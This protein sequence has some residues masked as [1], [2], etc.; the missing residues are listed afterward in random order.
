MKFTD[1]LRQAGQNL[2]R[3]KGRTLLTTLG[4]VVGC[5][6]VVIMISIGIGMQISTAATLAQMGDL[7]MITVEASDGTGAASL[8]DQA[9][10]GIEAIDGVVTAAPKL[11]LDLPCMIRVSKNDRYQIDY[12]TVVGMDLSKA[13]AVGYELTEGEWDEIK[14]GNALAGEYLAYEF[15]DTKRPEGYNRINYYEYYDWE[16][17][18]YAGLPDPYVDL[19]KNSLLLI[20]GNTDADSTEK[21][22]SA[23][24]Q[25]S[26]ILKQNWDKGYETYSGI[27]MDIEELSKLISTYNKNNDL[28]SSSS[29]TYSSLLVKVDDISHVSDVEKEIKRMGFQT[30]S[31][32]SIREPMEQE[33]QQKQMLLGCVGGVSFFVAALGIANTMIMAITERTREIGVMKALGCSLRDIRKLF[34]LEAGIIGLLGGLVGLCLSLLVSYIM[35]SAGSGSLFSTGYEYLLDDAAMKM[36]VIT[37]Q[38]ALA[39]V[40]FSVLVGVISGIYPAGKAVRISA[41]EAIRRE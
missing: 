2:F 19:E 39:A 41:L 4:V 33:M 8:N 26:G 14:N 38:L 17:D 30:S 18:S 7:T 29:V 28:K 3:H 10:A 24:I 12:V 1:I 6:S 34:L 23:Q 31:M 5:C 40:V 27:L 32:E 11:Q 21:T 15:T 36:S 9:V 35:N 22:A 37:W 25:I 20:V 16:T 13:E